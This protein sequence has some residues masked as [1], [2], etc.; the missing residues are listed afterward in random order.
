MQ[1]ADGGQ[2]QAQAAEPGPALGQGFGKAKDKAGRGHGESPSVT[3]EPA[4]QVHLLCF[5]S[6]IKKSLPEFLILRGKA[7]AT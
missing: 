1:P 2:R 3:L 7:R 6:V 5:F 4:E